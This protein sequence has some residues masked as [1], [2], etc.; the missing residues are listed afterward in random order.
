MCLSSF[1]QT[2]LFLDQGFK[3]IKIHIRKE[4]TLLLLGSPQSLAFPWL[5]LLGTH[6]LRHWRWKESR[7]EKLASW[8]IK[9]N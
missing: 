5:C 4:N 7:R 3:L 2:I 8:L 9:A 1:K 6:H